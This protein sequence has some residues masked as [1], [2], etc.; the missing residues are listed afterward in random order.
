MRKMH[1]YLDEALK[2]AKTENDIK[3]AI[4]QA[5]NRVEADWV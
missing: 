1:T 3:N 2:G 4:S 5:Y